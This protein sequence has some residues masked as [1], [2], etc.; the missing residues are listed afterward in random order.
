MGTRIFSPAFAFLY[1]QHCSFFHFYSLTKNLGRLVEF[2]LQKQNKTKIPISLL[3]KGKIS[4]CI[5]GWT[6]YLANISN[7]T[8]CIM[9]KRWDSLRRHSLTPWKWSPKISKIKNFVHIKLGFNNKLIMK[10]LLFT[11]T[12][13]AKFLNLKPFPFDIHLSHKEGIDRVFLTHLTCYLN[14]IE[15]LMTP[16]NLYEQLIIHEWGIPVVVLI[17]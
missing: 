9:R 10:N 1:W 5:F 17:L 14:I 12:Y 8:N 16:T 13:L 15:N 6:L 7:S 2:T 11:F 4:L 3:K